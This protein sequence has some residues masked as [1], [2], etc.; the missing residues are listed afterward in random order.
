MTFN[1]YANVS[2]LDIIFACFLIV[3][4]NAFYSS[5]S[6]YYFGCVI[7]VYNSHRL[8]IQMNPMKKNLMN[9]DLNPGQLVRLVPDFTGCCVA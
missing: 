4:L 1:F 7:F 6:S 2:S 5:V 9:L 8:M 3:S